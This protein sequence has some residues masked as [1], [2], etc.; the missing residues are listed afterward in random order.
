MTAQH[1]LV[2]Y[3]DGN[4]WSHALAWFEEWWVHV[5]WRGDAGTVRY[6]AYKKQGDVSYIQ[7]AGGTITTAA[8]FKVYL[9]EALHRFGGDAVAY[10]VLG[11]ERPIM[12]VPEASAE[13]RLELDEMYRR[14]AAL[15]KTPERE[16]RSKYGHMNPGLQI[17]N[18]KNRLRRKGYNT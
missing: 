8:Q 2:R 18:L 13:K 5:L 15:L 10:E 1:L 3:H 6:Q 14:V 12:P 17:M 7:E 9:K 11:V 16:L 4:R